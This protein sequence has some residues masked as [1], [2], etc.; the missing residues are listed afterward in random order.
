M[1]RGSAGLEPSCR[2]PMPSSPFRS[3][4]TVKL[5]RTSGSSLSTMIAPALPAVTNWMD[6]TK[7]I[8]QPCSV[9]SAAST[10][11]SAKVPVHAQWWPL[12][13]EMAAA[14]RGVGR[15]T[16][17]SASAIGRRPM[18]VTRDAPGRA[19]LGTGT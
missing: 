16:R 10:R 18:T 8:G 5:R 13:R 12:A 7:P 17:P 14:Q 19:K 11:P 3:C 1:L 4:V 6:Q 2:R 15:A 9:S